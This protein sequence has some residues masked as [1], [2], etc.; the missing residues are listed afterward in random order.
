MLLRSYENC[1]KKCWEVVD[2]NQWTD[3]IYLLPEP[4]LVWYL[5]EYSHI[6]FYWCSSYLLIPNFHEILKKK[7]K[8]KVNRSNEMIDIL[9]RSGL[10]ILIESWECS[11]HSQYNW[12][13][14]TKQVVGITIINYVF[15]IMHFILYAITMNFVWIISIYEHLSP[16][17]FKC[18]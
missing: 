14:A 7:N 2:G 9:M 18:V 16:R 8:K 11:M 3:L 1:I 5:G 10:L 13:R 6:T 12:V 4:L 17:T 15:I